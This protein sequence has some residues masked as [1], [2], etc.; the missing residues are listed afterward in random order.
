M[1]GEQA[2]WL[3]ANPNAGR[4]VGLTT[5]AAGPELACEVLGRHGIHSLLK[6]TEHERHASELAR[7]A[8]EA[9]ARLVIAAGG[10]GT[11]R[12]VAC[13]LIG[14]DTRL[15]IFPLGSMMNIARS[16][17]VPRDLD[18]AA[19]VI[20]E[21]RV[22]RMDVGRASTR[23]ASAYFLEAAGVGLD[24]AM[25]TYGNQIDKGNW[26]ALRP[27]WRYLLH[28]R[29]RSA[30]LVVDRRRGRVRI[31]MLTV[32]IT[33]FTGAALA[34]APQAKIDDGLFDVVL[35]SGTTWKS[36]VRHAIAMAWTREPHPPESITLRGRRVEVQPTRTRMM[37]HADGNNLGTTPA[38]FEL[39]PHALPVIVGQP[40]SGCP[41]T[42]VGEPNAEP[43]LA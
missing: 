12:E 24:A 25:F 43:V 37:V 26:G 23:T 29:P 27:L 33:P 2:V 14:T 41:Y 22:V 8:V 11:V 38:R 15:G 18:A 20:K 32:A 17:N 30:R 3:I 35:R 31:L 6:V 7:A 28:F 13:G 4:K 10:D 39:I 19:E 21:G 36:L 34:M 5:N 42:I 16:L 1:D 40:Q 9:G